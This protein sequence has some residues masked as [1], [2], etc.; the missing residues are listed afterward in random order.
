MTQQEVRALAHDLMSNNKSGRNL[1]EEGWTFEFSKKKT[2]LGTCWEYKKLIEI[3]IYSIENSKEALTDT[4]LHEMAHAFAGNKE[5]HNNVWKRWCVLLGANPERGSK[6]KCSEITFK[7]IAE[8]AKYIGTCP[9][10]HTQ[11]KH[12]MPSKDYSCGKCSNVFDRR[13]LYTWRD[14]Q[15]NIVEPQPKFQSK[16]PA[17]FNTPEKT[18]GQVEVDAVIV[19]GGVE[20]RITGFNSR[21]PKNCVQLINIK[22]GTEATCSIET[23]QKHLKVEKITA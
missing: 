9:N 1:L 23:A 10:G 16:P 2:S 5:G 12:K 8:V 22:N 3:S 21:A 6:G 11:A 19:F 4:I 17:K 13:Y 7:K 14:R 18:T 15:G 20:F